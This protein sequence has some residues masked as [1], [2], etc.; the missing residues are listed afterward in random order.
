MW[1]K[2]KINFSITVT[3]FT[4]FSLLLISMTSLIIL[5]T[6]KRNTDSALI[7]SDKLM[8]K[9]SERILSKI[10][11]LYAPLFLILEQAETLYVISEKP[12]IQNHPGENYFFSAIDRYPQIQTMYLGYSDGDFYE[13][14]SL[15]GN[16]QEAI[17][18][19]ILAPE[20]ADYAVLRQFSTGESGRP[21]RLWKY[22]NSIRQIIGSRQ[23]EAADY[24]PRIRPWYKNAENKDISIRTEPYLFA[25]THEIG[26]TLSRKLGGKIDCIMG[27]DILL[28]EIALFFDKISRDNNGLCFIVNKTGK[29]TYYPSFLEKNAHNGSLYLKDLDFPDV[30]Y[31]AKDLKVFKSDESG[32]TIN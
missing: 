22:M 32:L 31:I 25:I 11:S 27:I 6:Y 4:V 16:S 19:A 18:K 21:V 5:I 13:V 7:T 9:T 1:E 23:E 26:I 30:R 29:I 14:F 20:D 10:E 3:I 28:N 12:T 8:N 24:D 15:Q 17:K 2:N